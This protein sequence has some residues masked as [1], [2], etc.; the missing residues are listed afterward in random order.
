MV[1]KQFFSSGETKSEGRLIN[2]MDC[3]SRGSGQ[4]LTIEYPE[5]HEYCV[6]CLDKPTKRK[7]GNWKYF[8]KSGNLRMEGVFLVLDFIGVPSVRDGLWN[9]YYENGYLMQQSLYE[10]GK[11]IEQ[12]YFDEDE[13]IIE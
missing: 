8:Y 3:T 13:I 1:M 4:S 10:K 2:V 11:I 12:H 7:I 9:T 5:G 6:E